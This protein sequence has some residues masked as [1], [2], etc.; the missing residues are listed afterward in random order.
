M[1]DMEFTIAPG[2]IPAVLSALPEEWTIT[3][4]QFEPHRA[5]VYETQLTVGNGRLAARGS[6]E[7]RHRGDIPGSFIAGVYDAHDSIVIDLVNAPDWLDTAVIASGVRLDV[8]TCTVV[9][10]ERA[11]DIAHGVLWRSTVFEDAEGRRTRLDTVRT[12][13]MR[14]RDIAVLRVEV[15]PLN[16]AGEFELITGIDG[17]RTNMEALPVYPAGRTF[18]TVERNA[19]WAR[20]RHLQTVSTGAAG[21]GTIALTTRTLG[22]D[23]EIALATATSVVPAA[24]RAETVRAA[25]SVRR[26]FTIA[27]GQGETARLDKVVAVRTSRDVD[28]VDGE[29]LAERAGALAVAAAERGIDALLAESAASWDALWDASDAEVLGDALLSKAVRFG[30]YHLLITVNPEDPTVNIGAKSL[31]G[32]GYR[33]HVFWDTEAVMLP[34]YLLT[35]P[36]A[37]RALLGYR[38]NTLPGARRNAVNDGVR[39]ARFAWESAATGDEECPTMS[40]DG[41]DRFWTR[42]EEVHV[43]AD[44]AYA[45]QRYVEATGDRDYLF[46]EGAEVLFDTA[47]FWTSFVQ[48]DDDGTAHLRRVMG[49]DEFHSHVD[50]NAFTNFIVRWH[51]EYAAAVFDELAA[52]APDR[53]AEVVATIG[54]DA[55]E[56]EQWRATA[57]RLV[58]ASENAD[59]VIEQ[60]AG[61]FDRDDVAVT[62]WDENNMPRYP[63][64][65]H[66]FN[67][68]TTQLLKQPDVLQVMLMF[69]DAFSPETKR[70][71]FDYYEP[72]TLHKSSLSPS[73]HATVGLNVGDHTR[74]LQYF[75]RSALVDLADNQGNTHE[76]MHI[77]SAAGTWTT[78]VNGF[79]G[80]QIDHGELILN[81][82]IPSEWEGVRYRITWRGL[83]LHVTARHDETRLQLEG[84][85][86]ETLTLTCAGRTVQLA[87]GEDV[88]LAR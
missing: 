85:A 4:T 67:C 88:V 33:G 53:L 29:D 12:A 32:E 50:D 71:N 58:Q 26:R 87:T 69:P 20:S 79:G 82:W 76:G 40:A 62:E 30:I 38:Y 80:L 84:P 59:G 57:A 45:I 56:P 48:T 49:P 42:E 28:A 72:R 31:S 22:S 52:Q 2:L 81:P 13:S 86:G 24:S 63:E 73:V 78:L 64:G 34:F 5:N 18:T 77:A 75:T 8:D 47:R 3:Q 41:K 68:E 9:S 16:H 17:D 35:N 44:V 36:A 70:A 83:R 39:G 11:L 60:F 51:L 25:D 10:H 14:E 19:K 55:D 6:H 21:D 46:G 15:T 1:N 37:A 54:L 65:Y 7:E 74:A 43:T 66:H 61:Y 23:V 27:L